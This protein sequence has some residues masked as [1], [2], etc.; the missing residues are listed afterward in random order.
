MSCIRVRTTVQRGG[1]I[2]ADV[3]SFGGVSASVQMGGISAQVDKLH[4]MSATLLAGGSISA[5]LVCEAEKAPYLL[6]TPA[7]PIWVTM[8]ESG[9]YDIRSNTD[10]IIE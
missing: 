5:Y 3:Q 6:V 9:V 2:A 1:G 10:W 4:G 8:T 7:H